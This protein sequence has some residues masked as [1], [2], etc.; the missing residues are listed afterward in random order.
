MQNRTKIDFGLWML[1]LRRWTVILLPIL[2][3]TSFTPYEAPSPCMPHSVPFYG[4][5]FFDADFV[6]ASAAYA[7]F[8]LRF[9]D[10]YERN[11]N[12]ATLQKK[13]NC[14]EWNERFCSK[15][16]WQEVAAVIYESDAYDLARLHE[17]AGDPTRKTPLP[18]RLEDNNFAYILA[19][20]GC[21]EVTRYLT[22]AKRC[23]EHVVQHGDK[24][25]PEQRNASAMMDLIREGKQRFY[26]TQSHFVRLRYVYQLVRL[27]HY[28][29]AWQMTLDLYD[30]LMPKVDRK[31]KSVIFYWTL[32]HVAGAMQKLGKYPE[33]AYRYSLIFRSCPSKRTQA[34]RSFKI[35]NDDDWQKALRLCNSDEEKSTLYILRAG[36]SHTW[37]VDDMETIYELN[38]Q[39]P[40]LELLLVSDV[41]ELEK[42]YL[43]SSV[44]DEKNGRAVGKLKREAAAKH[45]LDL[46]KFV[47]RVIRENQTPNLKAWRAVDGYLEL[48]AKDRY[49][50]AKTWDRLE[51]DLKT[52]TKQD[53][54]IF[55]QIEIWRCLLEVM[56][57]DTTASDTVDRLAYKVR[58]LSAFK[59]NPYFEPFLQEW[60]SAGYA[61][62]HHPGKAMIAAYAP[63]TIR[64]NPK[65]EVIEDLLRL[66]NTDHPTLLEQTMMIDTNPERIKAYF[67]ETKGVYFLGLGEP[68][69]AAAVMRKISPGEQSR[70]TQFVPFANRY[71][72]KIDRDPPKG[73]ALNRLQIV[74]Q[75]IQ[76]EQQA[77]AAEAL[78]DTG[79]AKLWLRLGDFWYNTSYFGYEWEV[80]DFAR[81]GL[82]QLRLAQGPV[83]PM[84]GA[85]DGNRENLDLTLAF[86]Y[87]EKAFQAAQTKEMKART[88]FMAARCQQKQW[89]CTPDCTYRP[90]N[91]LIPILPPE[92]S[93]Y[94][95]LLISKYSKTR[96]FETVVKECK[97]LAAYAR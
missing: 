48:L 79:E 82:N 31:K 78:Q 43:R 14:E 29:G 2:I 18:S 15:T 57:L 5:S 87:Y 54:N 37:A 38:P 60:L 91:K 59:Q 80:R 81:D 56:N 50:A 39:N 90:G 42:I 52:G 45:L 33:A 95:D 27:A 44:T 8:F 83:F 70:M 7:P 85:P 47:R 88:A 35:R 22:F 68:E 89:F 51:F 62:N 6:D 32:G 12:A 65:I 4:Y 36:G 3:F 11:Y 24:W 41:Q 17:A 93:T 40:Q 34:Y 28:A 84:E 72:E 58:S 9:G 20:N 10:Y 26:D 13:G 96:Y 23:E 53:K 55:Q 66:A 76:F 25:N 94:Y 97:W 64:Y 77:K 71:G 61:S 49:A 92:Y 67:L 16:S 63:Q 30:E 46:Q 19:Y 75:L 74:E 1:D 73:T 86:A 69:A 21:V